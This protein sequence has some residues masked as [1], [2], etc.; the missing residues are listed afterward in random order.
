M[1]DL[2][3]LNTAS[4]LTDRA[5]RCCTPSATEKGQR[6]HPE[7]GHQNLAVKAKPV[8]LGGEDSDGQ[9]RAES[10]IAEYLWHCLPLTK[11]NKTQ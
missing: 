1:A 11:I 10:N 6:W 7:I 5:P 4:G 3:S 2:C 9:P 8:Y